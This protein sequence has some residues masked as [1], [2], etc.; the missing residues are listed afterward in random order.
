MN[1]VFGLYLCLLQEMK[2]TAVQQAMEELRRE[3]QRV[4][5]EMAAARARSAKMDASKSEQRQKQMR[6]RQEHEAEMAAM[7]GEL[8]ALHDQVW[9]HSVDSGWR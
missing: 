1:N 6:L 8:Q 7:R 2:R 9:L 3:Q 5:E 4:E